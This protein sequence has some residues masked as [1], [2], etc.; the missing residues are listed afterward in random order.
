MLPTN[1]ETVSVYL[2]IWMFFSIIFVIVETVMKLL[3][4]CM[5]NVNRDACVVTADID[6]FVDFGQR[7]VGCF[8]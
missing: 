1:S 4:C 8:A 7:V 5:P 2:S 6:E 3:S